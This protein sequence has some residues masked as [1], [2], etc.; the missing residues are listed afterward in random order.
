LWAIPAHPISFVALRNF[1]GKEVDPVAIG[2][3]FTRLRPR[4]HNAPMHT[5]LG[6]KKIFFIFVEMT[7]QN[8]TTKPTRPLRN[9]LF[10]FFN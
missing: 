10:G 1:R 9:S 8:Q 6:P 5:G 3:V 2:I 4:C 7:P